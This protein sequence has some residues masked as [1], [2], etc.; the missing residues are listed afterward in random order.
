MPEQ[1]DRL[2]FYT[3]LYAI[4]NL[5]ELEELKEEMQDRFGPIPSLV[6]RLLLVAT[7]RYYASYALFER[8][9]MQRK[10][11]NILLPKGEKE[12]YYK[13]K[14][15]ELMR[16]ILDQHKETVKFDQKSDLMKL[17]IKNNFDSPEAL[18][19]FLI[20]FSM[21]VSKLFVPQNTETKSIN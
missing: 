20:L 9:I 7:L 1:M 6:R 15:V 18:L 17:V 8:I 14:F 3:A 16:F 5:E 13:F 10:T 11:V 12:D 21:N 4:K 19:G 2:N